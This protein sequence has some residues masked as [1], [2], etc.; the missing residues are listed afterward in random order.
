MRNLASGESARCEIHRL[1]DGVCD[2]CVFF[3]GGPAPIRT[4]CADELASLEYA[5]GVSVGLAATGW[6]DTSS[7]QG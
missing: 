1:Q 5:L 2:V 7:E 4:P 3:D 6:V